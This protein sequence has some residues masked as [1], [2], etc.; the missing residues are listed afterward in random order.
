MI[1][2][3]KYVIYIHRRLYIFEKY[4]SAKVVLNVHIIW[5]EK[6]QELISQLLQ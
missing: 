3:Y 5:E 4:S 1:N 6:I 2:Y